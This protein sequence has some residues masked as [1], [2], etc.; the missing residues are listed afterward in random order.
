M[1][2]APQ[3]AP[4]PPTAL[5]TLDAKTCAPPSR[6]ACPD[7]DDAG[8]APHRS[9]ETGH[10]GQA[11]HDL[12]GRS[13][14]TGPTR[15]QARSSSTTA[16]RTAAARRYAS[17][18]SLRPASSTRL[19][20]L[21]R[22][23]GAAGAVDRRHTAYGLARRD[24]PGGADPPDRR[25]APARVVRA[26]GYVPATP[27]ATCRATVSR[28]PAGQVPRRPSRRHRRHA[29]FANTAATARAQYPK[30]TGRRSTRRSRAA[31]PT[32]RPHRVAARRVP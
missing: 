19:P 31:S 23:A 32:H 9:R 20:V 25:R 6:A 26:R 13:T 2:A 10:H 8:G 14:A 24:E 3:P 4:M 18:A 27:R 1:P 28:R 7:S 5:K 29:D 16:P 30:A 21:T 15:W 12:S 17:S 11:V 22:R